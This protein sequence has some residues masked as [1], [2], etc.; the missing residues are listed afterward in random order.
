MTDYCKQSR[1]ESL[2]ALVLKAEAS[3]TKEGW[4]QYIE[5]EMTTAG[6]TNRE[7]RAEIA[8]LRS[9]TQPASGGK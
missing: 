9:S 6:L 3:G 5:S 4:R 7:L 1:L 8:R 2:A